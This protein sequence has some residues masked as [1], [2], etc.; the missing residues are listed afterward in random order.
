MLRARREAYESLRDET[1]AAVLG[2]RWDPGYEALLDRLEADARERLGADAAIQRDPPG[3]G[4]VIAHDGQ[5]LIDA[6]L[7]VLAARALEALGS[8]VDELWA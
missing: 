4:G 2:L 3:L 6:T 8:E 5:R 1:V 7:P